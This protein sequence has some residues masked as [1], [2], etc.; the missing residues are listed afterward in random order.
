MKAA[1]Y[2][3][4]AGMLFGL[5]LVLTK[6]TL[7]FLHQ[8][9]ATML[10]HWECYALA[11]AGVVGFV[12]QQVSLGT[13]RLSPSVATV[14]VANPIVGI[15]IGT[16]LFDERLSRPAWHVVIAVIGLGL[17]L[18]G[19]VAISLAH[20]VAKEEDRGVGAPNSP[21]AKV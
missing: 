2:G 9:V 16:L 19:A 14:S 20:E 7:V 8:S 3:T 13:G 12:L 15:L 21:V 5:S 1:V 17:A 10:S 11:I 18:A 4:V 6:P